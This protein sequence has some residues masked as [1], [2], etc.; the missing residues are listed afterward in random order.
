MTDLPWLVSSA[1][2]A[3]ALGVNR[4]TLWRWQQAGVVRPA[5]RTSGGHARWNLDQLIE[6]L[7]NAQEMPLSGTPA[8][9]SHNL[10]VP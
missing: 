7:E 9:S 5:S 3:R 2:A 8:P 10:P 6:Q 4:S 1:A